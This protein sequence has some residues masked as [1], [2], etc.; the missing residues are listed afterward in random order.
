V[1]GEAKAAPN[2][3]GRSR[4]ARIRRPAAIIVACAVD[5]GNSSLV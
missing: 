3:V 2:A 1:R 5:M 4:S